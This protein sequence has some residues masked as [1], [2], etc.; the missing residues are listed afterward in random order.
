MFEQSKPGTTAEVPTVKINIPENDDILRCPAASDGENVS[1][2]LFVYTFCKFQE[3][4]CQSPCTLVFRE[5]KGHSCNR[6][7][8]YN[9]PLILKEFKEVI[10]HP[11]CSS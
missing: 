9:E 10:R 6:D 5:N 11:P 4:Q 7:S 8:L 2:C 3:V 1:H